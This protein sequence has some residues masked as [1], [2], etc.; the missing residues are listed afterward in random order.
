MPDRAPGSP[1]S[2]AAAALILAFDF[3]LKRIGVAA[4]DT[5]TRRASPLAVVSSNGGRVDWQALVRLVADWRPQLL[6]VGIPYNADGS[7]STL[8]AR[9]QAFAAELG[10]RTGLEVRHADERYSSL[11]A[12]GRLRDARRSGART[13][14]VRKGD[15]DRTAACI[16]LERWL[17]GA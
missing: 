13:R 12:E 10:E 1:P 3:G 11:E 17:G 7:D 15:V 9:A 16:I 8:T 4:G 6:V 14:R 2:P 5:L